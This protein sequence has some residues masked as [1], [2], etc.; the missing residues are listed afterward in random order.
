[1]GKLLHICSPLDNM[2]RQYIKFFTIILNN[3]LLIYFSAIANVLRNIVR[4]EKQYYIS[5]ST[6]GNESSVG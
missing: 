4:N 1:M 3:L 2:L 5:I 6:R